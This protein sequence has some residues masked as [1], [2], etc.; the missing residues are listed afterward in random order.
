[1]FSFS[2]LTVGWGSAAEAE[3]PWPRGVLSQPTPTGQAVVVGGS[4]PPAELDLHC[5][6]AEGHTRCT[7]GDEGGSCMRL[8]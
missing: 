1:M 2:T 5:D 8:Q 3:E 6:E 4:L 7:L